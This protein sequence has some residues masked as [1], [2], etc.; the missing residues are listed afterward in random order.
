MEYAT[1]KSPRLIRTDNRINVKSNPPPNI[2]DLASKYLNG[3]RYFSTFNDSTRSTASDNI[4]ENSMILEV[5]TGANLIFFE[6]AAR[7][8]PTDKKRI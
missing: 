6:T 7:Q 1:T 2:M 4:N 5:K 3:V 8:N